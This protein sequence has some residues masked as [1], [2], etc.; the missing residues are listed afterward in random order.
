MS[1]QLSE[2]PSLPSKSLQCSVLV[3]NKAYVPVH[4]ISARRSIILLYRELAEVIHIEDGIFNNFDFEKWV[5]Y[6]D[7]L[8]EEKQPNDDWIQGTSFEMMVPR[9]VRLYRYDR[10]PKQTL[11]FNR[12]NLFA[13]DENTCQYCN[14]V[15]PVSQ[16]SFDHVIPR[17]RGG[18]T[19]WSN[20]VC[21]CLRCNTVKGNRTPKEAEMKLIRKPVKPFFSPIL[22][23]KMENPKYKI[24]GSFVQIGKSSHVD[25]C[26]LII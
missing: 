14:K 2:S 15:F 19:S 18:E 22:T 5:E 25:D 7:F 23:A 8:S 17:S 3:L 26:E 12:R 9:V 6:S 21:C 11:R 1:N 20:V 16:L 10:V 4:V 13:R 24:W